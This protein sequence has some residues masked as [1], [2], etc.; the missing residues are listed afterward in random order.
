MTAIRALLK[1]RRRSQRGSVL[2]GVLIMTAFIAIISG[3]LMTEL[4]T[5]FL[6]SNTMLNRVSYQATDNS[7]IE[8]A[9]SQLQSTQLNAP[10]PALPTAAVNNLMASATYTSCW[11][12]VREAQKFA[13][14]AGSSAQFDIDGVHAQVNGLNDY[15]V[16]DAGGTVYDLPF[17]SSAPRW[18]IPLGGSVTATPLVLPKPGSNSHVL[19]VIPLAGPA[20]PGGADCLMVRTDDGSSNTPPLGCAV[21]TIGGPVESGPAASPTQA[22]LVYYGD[23]TLLQATDMSAGGGCDPEATVQLPGGQAV[24]AGPVAFRCLS[25]CGRT[26]DDVYAVVSDGTSA[27]LVHYQYSSGSLASAGVGLSLP[28][29]SVSGI[30]VSASTL[31]A[32]MAISFAGGGFTL[33]QISSRGGMTPVGSGAVPAGVADA[34]YWCHCPGGDLFG[35]AAQNGGLYLY[36]TSLQLYASYA[37]VSAITTTPGAD[38]AGNWYF[39]AADG[40]IH[41]VQLLPGKSSLT[42]V[43][44]YGQVG[45]VTSSVLVGTCASGICV[46]FGTANNH[47]YLVPLDARKAVISACITN[48]PPTCSG[49]N[50]RLWASVEVGASGSPQT[51][52]VQGWSYYSG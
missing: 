18:T 42:Q 2:S 35:L 22:G 1:D 27:Q 32:E 12:A 20:C 39:G 50:P 16:G 10:C 5:N 25:G 24:V 48:S 13:Q 46:Y 3:A 4:S 11:P 15:V 21:Q 6:L 41:E 9:L 51:V 31:P 17:G 30:A 36:N 28:W 43:E 49:A 34:P 33:A 14:V 23:G 29:A 7:A 40:N 19:V 44:T 37:G 38:A 52:H 47:A 26:L 45:S 8:L